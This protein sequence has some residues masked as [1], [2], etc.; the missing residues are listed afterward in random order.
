MPY[1]ALLPRRILEMGDFS[2]L[3]P[4]AI[5]D[6][7]FP[8]RLVFACRESKLESGGVQQLLKCILETVI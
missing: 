2:H 4:L 1:V 5:D 6:F 3:L 7:N 8:A